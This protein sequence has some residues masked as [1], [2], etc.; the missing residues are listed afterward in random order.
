M[1][2]SCIIH[3][4]QVLYDLVLRT[5]FEYDVQDLC[6]QRGSKSS[7]S[8]YISKIIFFFLEFK[9]LTKWALEICVCLSVWRRTVIKYLQ[10]KF[11]KHDEPNNHFWLCTL[12]FSSKYSVLMTLSKEMVITLTKHT[13]I[14]AVVLHTCKIWLPSKVRTY[15]ENAGEQSV[16][17][18]IRT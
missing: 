12:A 8:V 7:A 9:I 18:H 14:F 5:G 2:R 10:M 13:T 3:K 6:I 1:I 11:C 16:E 15:Y 4:I 17:K